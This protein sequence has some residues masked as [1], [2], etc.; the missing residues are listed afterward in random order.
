MNKRILFL[1]LALPALMAGCATN[2]PEANRA[3]VL[4]TDIQKSSYSQGVQYM[5]FLQQNEIPLDTGLFL[6]GINDVLTKQPL[7]LNPQQ[8]QRGRDW[9][10]VQQMLHMDR[11]SKNNI[12]EGEAFLKKNKTEAGIASLA[13]GVQYKVLAGSSQTLTPT[14]KDTVAMHYRIKKRNGEVFFATD[15]KSGPEVLKVNSVLKGWQ[16][17]LLLMPEGSKWEIYV[18]GPL[19]YGENVAPESKIKPNELIIIEV[20]LVDIN[21]P[22]AM[23]NNAGATPVIKKTSSW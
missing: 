13:S 2:P 6:Q 21:P 18:P 9:V 16:E 10:Y 12:A 19:A 14:L 11:T 17:A 22:V 4:T 5:D 1:K 20:E 15:N 8:L 7:R 23:T 3:P